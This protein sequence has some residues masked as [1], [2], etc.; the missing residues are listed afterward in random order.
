MSSPGL[1]GGDATDG[2]L[3]SWV[4]DAEAMA[5]R[6]QQ[7]ATDVDKV[8]VSETTPDGLITVTVNSGGLLTDL[9]ITERA[10]GMPGPKIAAGVLWAMRRAQSRIAVQVAEVMR[11]TLGEDTAMVDAVMNRYQD[12]FPAPVEQVRPPV[13]DE[14]RIG[15]DVRETAPVPTRAPARRAAAAEDWDGGGND[16]FL[17]EVDR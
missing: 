7:L 8:S 15:N 10:T 5:V 2:A 6:Y 1:P 13:V 14:V 16:S 9:R 12:S 4:A 17:E 3:D 11:S